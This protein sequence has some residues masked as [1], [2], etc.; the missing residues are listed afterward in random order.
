MRK[1]TDCT[2]TNLKSMSEF[3]LG[4]LIG[5][6]EGEG[7]FALRGGRYPAITAVNTDFCTLERCLDITGVGLLTKIK[8]VEHRKPSRRWIVQ[9]RLDVLALSLILYPGM[10][11]RRQTQ[12][13]KVL[14][15]YNTPEFDDTR[16]KFGIR[17]EAIRRYD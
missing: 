8:E 2:P 15:Y 12:L 3:D 4:W 6:L 17:L 5:F 13:D 14:S 1:G 10:S 16:S 7:Y 9:R 11:P